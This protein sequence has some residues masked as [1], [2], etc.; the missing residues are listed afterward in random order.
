MIYSDKKSGF[1]ELH[2]GKD[3]TVSPLKY[4]SKCTKCIKI[5]VS[6]CTKVLKIETLNPESITVFHIPSINTV[7]SST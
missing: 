1:D 7:F 3:G 4:V 5:Y 6:K 2:S